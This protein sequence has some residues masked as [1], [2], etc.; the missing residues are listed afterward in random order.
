M[1]HEPGRNREH[2]LNQCTRDN[3]IACR[4]RLQNSLRFVKMVNDP[5]RILEDEQDCWGQSHGAKI[6]INLC[7]RQ[8]VCNDQTTALAVLDSEPTTFLHDIFV[9]WVY[10]AAQLQ[11][12]L[13][14]S[15]LRNL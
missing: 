4:F 15:M 5:D 11:P 9:L 3:H 2:H 10:L 13:T 1:K 8:E 6:M 7:D 12:S 14:V